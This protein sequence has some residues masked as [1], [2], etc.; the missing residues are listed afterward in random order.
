[1]ANLGDGMPPGTRYHAPRAA[2]AFYGC[3]VSGHVLT[4][5]YLPLVCFLFRMHIVK[6]FTLVTSKESIGEGGRACGAHSGA[7]EGPQRPAV[8]DRIQK[9]A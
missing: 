3:A 1:M 6:L 5:F 4:T 2:A 9:G 7:M 8:L